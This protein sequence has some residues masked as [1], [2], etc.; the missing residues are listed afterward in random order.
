MH[1]CECVGTLP[2]WEAWSHQ[3]FWS[4]FGWVTPHERTKVRAFYA[5]AFLLLSNDKE[6][7][8]K[9]NVDLGWRIR[10]QLQV[11]A[12]S[13]DSELILLFND[14]VNAV[15]EPRTS[16]SSCLWPGRAAAVER[17]EQRQQIHPLTPCNCCRI[18]RVSLFVCLSDVWP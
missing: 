2:I 7:K 9:G 4:D 12:K 5:I 10:K 11:L 14:F 8:K 17:K 16:S 3:R 13:L 1:I 15:E 6:A 18:I